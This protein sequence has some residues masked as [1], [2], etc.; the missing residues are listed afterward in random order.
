VARYLHER[1]LPVVGVD[2][3]PAMVEEA[4]RP[5]P[6]IAFHQGS[7]LDL[8]FPDEAFGGIAAFYSI[9]HVPRHLLPR[10]FSEMHR[11]LLPGGLLLLGFHIGQ[12]D[13]HLDEWME[14]KVNLDFYFFDRT[15]S[16]RCL[17]DAGFVVEESVERQPYP[18]VEAQTRRA[19]I[20][21]RRPA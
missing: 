20:R 8:D 21:A 7:M 18:E 6:G 12:E 19:Y 3:S 15:E 14:Q 13:V 16:E 1:G 11:T 17:A 2:L 10:A 5:N 9:I 4:Q